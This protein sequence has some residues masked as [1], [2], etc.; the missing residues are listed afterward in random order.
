MRAAQTDAQ[1]PCSKTGLI[2]SA[3]SYRPVIPTWTEPSRQYRRS[4]RHRWSRPVA[5]EGTEALTGFYRRALELVTSRLPAW[6]EIFRSEPLAGT[7][8][9]ASRL[10]LLSEGRVDHLDSANAY[11]LPLGSEP[12]RF[13]MCGTLAVYQAEGALL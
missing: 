13:G 2:R 3:K 6:Q 10:R 7:N 5:A 8:A 1:T 12:R 9:T 4:Q 11:A